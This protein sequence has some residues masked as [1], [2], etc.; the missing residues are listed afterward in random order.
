MVVLDRPQVTEADPEAL[1]KER[2][3]A[4]GGAGFSVRAS[5]S[6]WSQLRL[7]SQSQPAAV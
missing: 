3:G 6:W 1:F 5:L 7:H 4:A 2:A